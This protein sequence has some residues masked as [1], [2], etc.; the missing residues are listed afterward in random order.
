MQS[1]RFLVV[2]HK[3]HTTAEDELVAYLNLRGAEEVLNIRHAFSDAPDR[4]S[5]FRLY[6]RGRLVAEGATRDFRGWPEPLIYAKE[7]WFTLSWT[8]RFGGHWDRYVAVDGL[9]A[10]FGLLLRLLGRVGR[11]TFWSLDFVP[12]GRFVSRL[13]NAVYARVNRYAALRADEVWDHTP[14]MVEAKRAHLGLTPRDYRAHRVVP[15]GIWLE[16]IT[17]RTFEACE[18]NVL[19]FIGHLI[20]KQG[21]QRVIESI[22]TIVEAIPDFRFRVIGDGA[23][24]SALEALAERI[25]VSAHVQFIGR[26]EDDGAVEELIAGSCV[27]IAPYLR[28]LDTFTQFGADPGKVKNYLGCGVP[29]LV[30]DVP[31]IA[32]EV[33]AHGAGEV[34]DDTTAAIAAAVVRW[35][36]D[37]ELNQRAREQARE[38]ARSFDNATIFD[39]LPL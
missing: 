15:Y 36:R 29:V 10:L 7:L 16:R 17:A 12:S 32:R 18:R 5:A 13:R 14:L 35:M 8:L 30:T 11:V 19:V 38:F 22:P 23:Y 3:F 34:I 20:E 6:R 4:R 26:I 28:E 33:A 21:V 24:R 27:A 25:G 37:A 39:A 1:Q 9:L 31:W 2:A